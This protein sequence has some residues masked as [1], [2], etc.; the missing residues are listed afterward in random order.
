MIKLNETYST[1]QDGDILV[2]EYISANKILVR[3]KNTGTTLWT[4]A[5][6]IR[7]GCVRDT[8][9]PR[10]CGV[11]YLGAGVYKSKVKYKAT[12]FYKLW[13]GMLY[14]CYGVDQEVR[15]PTY[16]GVIVCPEWH[17][18][19]NF[20]GW[21][22]RNYPKSGGSYD[23]DKDKLISGSREYSPF[24]CSF[25]SRKENTQLA[26]KNKMYS[27]TVVSPDGGVFTGANQ[28][29]FCREHRLVQ[30]NFHKMITRKT[31]SHLGWRLR[32]A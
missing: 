2:I 27:F 29:E 15:N 5:Q 13:E 14:R 1:K 17:N 16:K 31:K 32:D 23:L 28:H 11:G 21:C 26:H 18:F 30:S 6:S 4:Y 9:K 20:A 19:Q 7:N 24:T 12:K 8:Y 3:F 10:I 22:E 25:I